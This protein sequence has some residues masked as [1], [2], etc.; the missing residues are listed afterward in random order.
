M[1][2]ETVAVET[3]AAERAEL[4]G[5]DVD[6]SGVITMRPVESVDI[7]PGASVT[8]ATGGLHVMLF[9]LAEP[10]KAGTTFNATLVLEPAGRV[11]VEVFVESVGATEPSHHDP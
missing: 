4:H 8:A 5:H 2:R 1:G 3:P 7:P 10:L 6:A 9:G 11:A